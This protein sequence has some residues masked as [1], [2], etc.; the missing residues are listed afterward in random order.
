MADFYSKVPKEYKANLRYRVELRKRCAESEVYRQAVWTACKNDF[1]FWLNAFCWVYE[2]RPKKVNGIEMPT[3]LPFLT[4][5]HQD[6]VIRE[7][8]Q[9]LG[10][11]S[12]GVIKSRGEGMSW[13]ACMLALHDWIFVEG[14]AV[15]LATK[16]EADADDP[17][18]P[19]SLMWK[20]QW[21][22]DKLPIW[23]VGKKGVDWDRNIDKHTFYHRR[24]DSSITAGACTS[25][26]FRGGRKRWVLTDEFAKWGK[27]KGHDFLQNINAV[28]ESV[29]YVSTVWGSDDAFYDIMTGTSSQLH[30]IVMDWKDN[31]VRRRGLYNFKGGIP[32]A[33]D[34]E[35]NPLPP[36]YNPPSQDVLDLFEELRARGY[37]LEGNV[38]SP[39][40]DRECAKAGMT[41]QKI[42]REYDMDWSGSTAK[43]FLPDFYVAARKTITAPFGKYN[44]VFDRGLVE[45][46]DSPTGK[47]KLW[48]YLD[49][50]GKPPAGKY[51]IGV[52]LSFGGG[53]SFTSNSVAI[54]VN[55]GTG[56]QVCEYVTNIVRPSDFADHCIGLARFFHGA[57][58]AWE[59]N[60]PG[61]P[62]TERVNRVGYSYCY[63]RKSMKGRRVKYEYG[64]WSKG[65]TGENMMDELQRSIVAGEWKVRSSELLDETD[66]YIRKDG[67]IYCPK[68]YY[69]DDEGSKGLAHG[70]RVMAYGVARQASLDM[71][72]SNLAED[73]HE[74][75]P[76]GSHAW[77]QK[78][79]ANETIQE[80]QE[81]DDRTNADL[82][83]GSGKRRSTWY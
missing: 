51:V 5:S 39:W 15:G 71:P 33:T 25:D 75:A 29:L 38:R 61:A 4:W 49:P 52:D 3:D 40:Y 42:A 30:K 23:M 12:I 83:S 82:I 21:Q 74:D 53:G 46:S 64:F 50:R 6:T 72:Q 24:S 70:D 26:T 44:I 80:D 76:F 79:I 63:E 45:L 81:W 13:I 54:V 62:F 35:N 16:S 8:R 68:S 58:L 73:S 59:R 27:E 28:T 48:C 14:A 11:K 10:Y 37:A 34:P 9:H 7:I 43:V 22:I 60:G 31:D 55:A 19:D 20:I 1:L 32:V 2:P 78:Q 18:N 66:G 69:T 67:N 17:K 77:L 65:G 47:V 41:P 57:Y 36:D 56:E